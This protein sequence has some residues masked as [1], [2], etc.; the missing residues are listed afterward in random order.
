MSKL[1]PQ[2][3]WRWVAVGPRAAVEAALSS[4]AR[5]RDT[6]EHAS[7]GIAHATLDGRLRHCNRHFCDMLGYSA[8]ELERKAIG[9]ITHPDDHAQGQ[10]LR[11]RLGAGEISSYQI[12]KR[13]VRKDGLGTWARLNVCAIRDAAGAVSYTIAVIESIHLRK[14]T[15]LAMHALNTDLVG[16]AF[17]RQVT[18]TLTELLDV[19]IAFV[20]EA[21]LES[22]QRFTARAVNVDGEFVPDLA[23]DLAGTPCET[24]APD[25]LCL[26]AQ[27]VQAQFPADAMLTTMGVESYAAVALGHA[28]A[29][30]A[31]LGVLAIMSRRPLRNA[32]AVRTLLPLLALRVGAELAYEREARKF[33]DLL[34]GSPLAIVLLD[35]QRTIRMISRAG[36]QLFGWEREGLVGQP[37]GVLFPEGHRDAYQAQFRRHI[38]AENRLPGTT[39]AEE[40]CGLRRDASFFPAQ[41][42]LRTLLT[43]EGRMTAAFV[44]DI[45]ERKQAQAALLK[46]I[47]ELED[48]VATRT[49]ELMRARDE[50]EQAS[51][52]KSAFLAAMSH[53]IRTPMNG[54]MGMLDVLEQTRLESEQVEIV[55]TVRQSA[56]ALL[57]ILDDVL[58]FSKIEA[59]HLQIDRE[60]VNVAA[61]S[62]HRAQAHLAPLSAQQTSAQGRSIP[63]TEDNEISQKVLPAAAT[64]PPDAPVP[65]ASRPAAPP[66]A[67]DV[68]VLQ[69]LI[70]DDDPEVINEFLQD[71]R[72]SA[73]S[74]AAQMRTACRGQHAELV[75]FLAHRLKSS[76]RSVGALALGDLCEQLEAASHAGQQDTLARLW[77]EFESELAAV[78]ELLVAAQV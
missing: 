67:L 13:L 37:L 14:L 53:E 66:M 5:Y 77:Q 44:Q 68:S 71:F 62:G 39:A 72:A 58:D 51:R 63:I 76:A 18:R 16:E 31:P 52:A 43:A 32:D 73:I 36:E 7:V 3:G 47:E 6:F 8:E 33:R 34:D 45:T 29:G 24:V 35:A 23:Y 2:K 15:R 9:D 41:I 10:R 11:E 19:E 54:V 50:A 61:E 48:K 78:D 26:H 30:Q 59:G 25:K 40:F 17:L 60:P 55:Q 27:Q 69:A 4:E 22:S 38:D 56:H 20:G 21:S 57:T 46:H 74:T 28:T 1:V 42:Y 64:H 12:E 49:A 65:T 75:E 70:G